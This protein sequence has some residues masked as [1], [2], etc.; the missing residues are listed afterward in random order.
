MPAKKTTKEFISDAKKIFGDRY[1]YSKVQY[2]NGRDK[3]III[4]PD[5]GEF[6][7]SPQ[8]HIAGQGCRE[9]VGYVALTQESFL[10]RSTKKHGTQYNY[11][12]TVVVGKNDKVDIKCMVH[13]FFQQL[14]LNHVQGAG[15]PECAKLTRASSQSYTKDEFIKSVRL[16]HNNI[17]DYTDVNY[18]N[19]QTKVKINCSIHG[20]FM[21][22]PN[23][24]YNG[25]GCPKCGRI[26]ANKNIALDYLTFLERAEKIHQNRYEYFEESFSNYT[27]KMEIF[28]SEHGFFKQTP[29][30]HVSMRAGCPKCGL[31]KSARSNQKGWESVLILFRDIHGD[32]YKYDESTYKDVSSKMKISC[33]IH[34]WFLQKP[35]Q[36]YSGSGCNECAIIDVHNRQKIDFIEFKERSQREHGYRYEYFEEDYIDIFTPVKISCEKHGYFYQKPR[37]HYRGSGCPKCQSSRG[38]N[39]V[40]LFL[41]ELNIEFQEQKTFEGLEFKSKLKCDFYI[42]S[43]NTVI[44]FNGLQHYEPISIFGGLMGLQE[45]QKR[46]IIKYNFLE[47]NNINLIVVRYDIEDI[48]HYLKEKIKIWNNR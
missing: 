11:S 3:V 37:D 40:R 2:S 9:C 32:K 24:H 5:H 22:K 21:M 8:K 4:C 20:G 29:H 26:S 28:C 25:Q 27:S 7:K 48:K 16:K 39:T 19:S 31:I 10:T 46:D 14:P 42:P 36:H 45:T 15:C 38:E 13:G 6:L 23:S 47:Q 30:T 17:Y 33:S 43:V 41:Q 35:Y 34:G 18:K 1:D 44:E 12:E